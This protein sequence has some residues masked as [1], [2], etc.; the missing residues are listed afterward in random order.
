MK[1]IKTYESF[2]NKKENKVNEEFLG[3][4]FKGLKNKLSLGFS[5]MFGNAA[6]IDKAIEEYKSEISKIKEPMIKVLSNYAN[7]KKET[8]ESGEVDQKKLQD[9]INNYKKEKDI[10]NKTKVKVKEKFDLKFKDITKDE[11]NEKVQSYI[12]L[13]KIEME[14]ELIRDEMDIVSKIGLT[15]SEIKEDD[16]LNNVI[17]DNQNR[18]KE[19]EKSANDSKSNL[20]S[21][22]SGEKSDQ[23]DFEA[24]KKDPENYKWS[25]SKYV[26]DYKFESGEEI[27]YWKKNGVK[28]EGDNYKGTTAYVMPDDRQKDESGGNLKPG[29]IRVVTNKDWETE[30]LN[31]FVIAKSKII[32]TKKDEEEAAK[33]AEESK[34]EEE[35]KKPEGEETV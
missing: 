35:T 32:T 23:F 7:Y 13:K 25:D 17:I 16:F 19:S 20:E 18:L 34:K 5:K 1:Y 28:N 22:N 9:L 6:A 4:L 21:N 2:R 33:K 10:Y 11:D 24:A 29:E 26:K 8:K 31:G 3:G 15:D 27:K 12:K 30:D 14:Q